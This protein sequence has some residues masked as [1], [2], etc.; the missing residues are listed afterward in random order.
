M[1]DTNFPQINYDFNRPIK[2]LTESNIWDEIDM[3][4]ADASDEA[5]PQPFGIKIKK[6]SDSDLP[7]C[8]TQTPANYN[9]NS[10]DEVPIYSNLNLSNQNLLDPNLSSKIELEDRAAEVGENIQ[11]N[12]NNSSEKSGGHCFHS[13]CCFK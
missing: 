9:F 6:L 7:Y 10:F 1:S 12:K 8:I 5:R 13:G 4:G 3:D 2:R 11:Q